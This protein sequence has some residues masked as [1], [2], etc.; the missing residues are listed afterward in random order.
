[1]AVLN[2]SRVPVNTGTGSITM[3]KFITR[4]K[5]GS[6]PFRNVLL[7]NSEYKHKCGSKTMIKTFFRLIETETLS[8][9]DLERFN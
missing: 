4:F 3:E 8:E 1:L 7:Y 9:S 6:K 2:R 5:K